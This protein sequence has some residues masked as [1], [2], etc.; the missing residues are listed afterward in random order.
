[1][2]VL[3]S[4]LGLVVA[5][6]VLT[7]LNAAGGASGAPGSTD[8]K[9]ALKK[10]ESVG[11]SS[12]RLA[13]IREY[14]DGY[15]QRG[16]IAGAVTL[17]ARHGSIVHFE[18]QGQRYKEEN[19]PMRTDTIFSLQSMTKPIVSTALMLLFEEGRFRLI[20]PVAKYLPAFE[21]GRAHV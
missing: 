9:D 12:A 15:M 20:D 19:A 14:I 8:A 6:G 3:R 18:A 13:R 4:A 21:I 17:V 10:P 7:Q 16:E 11:M 1:M 2:N 5:V